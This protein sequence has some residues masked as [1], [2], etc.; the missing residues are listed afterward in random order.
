MWV[1]DYNEVEPR[2]STI[3]SGATLIRD[4]VRPPEDK[5][6]FVVRVVDLLPK[7]QTPY[8]E[9]WWEH[10]LIILAGQGRIRTEE[11]ETRV[12]PGNVVFI[13][14]GEKHQFINVGDENLCYICVVPNPDLENMIPETVWRI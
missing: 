9:H 2:E 1:I 6:H 14:G 12:G 8:H 13:P 11:K 10:T 3:A 5:S 4:L 7:E